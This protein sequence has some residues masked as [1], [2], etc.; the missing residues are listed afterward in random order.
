[1]SDS[2]LTPLICTQCN[3][4]LEVDKATLDASFVDLGN[5]SFMFIGGGKSGD[6]YT[7]KHCETKFERKAQFQAAQSGGSATILGN[8]SGSNIVMGNNN[9]VST[10]VIRKKK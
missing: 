7:C 3:G 2:D 5:G 1:M 8:V 6:S 10:R 9:F 4:Q